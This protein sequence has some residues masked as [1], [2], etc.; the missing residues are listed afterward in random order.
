MCAPMCA[1]YNAI[2]GY[3]KNMHLLTT[4]VYYKKK[5]VQYD[6]ILGYTKN[7]HLL[8]TRVQMDSSTLLTVK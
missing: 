5:F 4:H 1:Q 7:V 2:L 3:T 8:T 6:A